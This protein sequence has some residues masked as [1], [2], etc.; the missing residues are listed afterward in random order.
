[1]PERDNRPRRSQRE[2][3]P[4]IYVILILLL[5]IGAFLWWRWPDLHIPGLTPP[6]QE[7]QSSSSLPAPPEDQPSE[8]QQEA[9]PPSDMPLPGQQRAGTPPTHPIQ[10]P[11]DPNLPPLGESDS[12]VN[13]A[14]N[15]LVGKKAGSMLAMDGF[16]RRFVATVDNL[17]REYAPSRV[18]PVQTTSPQFMVSGE[19]EAQAIAADNAARYT[20]M[21][22]LAEQ[23]DPA[24]A[25]SIYFRLYPLFQE[26]YEELGYGDRYFNDRLVAVIDHLLA[27]PEP[28]EPVRL[29]RVEVKSDT[30]M[31]RPWAHYEFADPRLESMSAGQKIMVR[32]G[33]VN[34]RRLKSRLRAFRAQIVAGDAAQAAKR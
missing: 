8:P 17:P 14:V 24:T 20:P 15:N 4:W 2:S 32:V 26:A 16:V 6:A 22:L 7:Q 31:S 5:L 27:A 28:A 25:A 9:T 13:S 1:M 34:E 29:T 19:G 23:V 11:P 33:L 18:W 3:S 21:V 12:K 10:T 30:P